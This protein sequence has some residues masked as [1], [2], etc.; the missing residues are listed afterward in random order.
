[1]GFL[2]G[3]ATDGATDTKQKQEKQKG[4]EIIRITDKWLGLEDLRHLFEPLPKDVGY[5][6]GRTCS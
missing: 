3:M 5:C 4:R 2:T 1:M 6:L